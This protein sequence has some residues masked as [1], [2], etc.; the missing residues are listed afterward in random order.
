MKARRIA[1]ALGGGT[2]RGAAHIGA[3]KVLEQE[4]MTPTAL[5]GTSAGAFLAA[6]YALGTPATA[7]EHLVRSQNTLEIWAQGID[8]GLHKGA[9]AHGKRFMRWLDRKYFYGATFAD[10]DIPLKIICTDVNTGGLVGLTEGSLAK[11]VMASSSLPG[12]FAP[13]KWRERWLID[14]GFVATVPLAAF[15]SKDFDVIVGLHAGISVEESWVIKQLLRFRKTDVG[16]WWERMLET[17]P[18]PAAYQRLNRG[19]VRIFASYEQTLDIPK[20]AELIDLS[21]PIAWWD[22]HRTP[23]AIAAGEAA[24]L[25]ALKGKVFA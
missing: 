18:A 8:F 20:G 21:P 22:F 25:S 23:E 12:L 13:I 24:M 4:G 15:N 16:K 19:I 11:A 3:L 5:A 9:I 6:L 2:A 1:L 14:G 17:F 10:T 7:L